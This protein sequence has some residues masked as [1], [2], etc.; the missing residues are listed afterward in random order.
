MPRPLEQPSALPHAG[1]T[2]HL[3][4]QREFRTSL[5]LTAFV[6]LLL[7]LGLFLAARFQSK[8]KVEQIMWL[9]GGLAGGGGSAPHSSPSDPEPEPESDPIPEPPKH[10]PAPKTRP[11]PVIPSEISQPK[12]TPAPTPK[13]TTPKPATPK[14][15]TPKVTPKAT[16]NATPTKTATPKPKASPS[17]TSPKPAAESAKASPAP[18]KV[19]ANDTG[20]KPSNVK[21]SGKGSGDMV[22]E[23]K[24]KG[25]A[26]T[27]AGAGK[28]SDF[29]WYFALLRDKYYAVWSPPTLPDSASLVATLKIRVKRDGSVL[30]YDLIKSSGNSLMDG[31]VL[32]AAR[33]V[34]QIDP[35][36]NGLG[37]EDIVEIPVNFKPE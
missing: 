3:R 13:L 8:P 31:S 27:G 19:K 28:P 6:H 29:G 1:D 7:L 33:Q 35:L 12:P 32:E 26:G 25:T 14:P 2:D 9:D 37:K 11:E 18:A 4:Q 16:P 30:G 5:A 36:P 17:P 15:A 21:T 20:T 10:E 24:G 34:T 23:G 22:G